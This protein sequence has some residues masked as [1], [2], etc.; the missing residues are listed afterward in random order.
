[1]LAYLGSNWESNV[2]L[3][4][5]TG[6]GLTPLAGVTSEQIDLIYRKMGGPFVAK[7]M[8]AENWIEYGLG[9]YAIRWSPEDLD[10][11]GDFV[12]ELSY[13]YQ[14]DSLVKEFSVVTPPS[15]FGVP[16]PV[17]ILSGNL[18]D[19]GGAPLS[20]VEVVIRPPH[21]PYYAGSTLVGSGLIRTTTDAYGNFSVRLLRETSVLVEIDKAGIRYLIN[22]P[23]SATAQLVDL[24]PVIP[25]P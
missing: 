22:I 5:D 21:V 18:V 3:M 23:D 12:F 25:A 24:L 2:R 13:P 4:A 16:A 8:S 20:S 1:M 10:T 17:C 14:Q 11:I 15:S 19:I 7:D 6:Y 9:H